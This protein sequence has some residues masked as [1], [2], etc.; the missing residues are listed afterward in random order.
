MNQ[1]RM[2]KI[3]RQTSKHYLGV[4]LALLLCAPLLPGCAF[5]GDGV[6]GHV[7][8]IIDPNKPGVGD[9]IRPLADAYVVASW[10]GTIPTPAHASGVCLAV[11]MVRSDANGQYRIPGW[12]KLPKLYPVWDMRRGGIYA[13]KGGY[14][15]KDPGTYPPD[16]EMYFAKSTAPPNVRLD[17]LL[18]VVSRTCSDREDEETKELSLLYKA[19][20]EE[21]K[22]L[23]VTLNTHWMLKHIEDEARSS[24]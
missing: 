24:D 7:Y 17:F 21:A 20:Y 3:S 22:T 9:N 5:H 16:N 18:G 1:V 19:V 23:P 6:T 12:L 13:Y 2:S 14:E 4:L 11:K 15:G 8:E 10:D